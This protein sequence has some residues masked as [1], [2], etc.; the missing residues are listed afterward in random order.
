MHCYLINLPT[1]PSLVLLIRQ[2]CFA[3]RLPATARERLRRPQNLQRDL[4]A[5]QALGRFTSSGKLHS[6][7]GAPNRRAVILQLRI[8][9]L[10]RYW[11]SKLTNRGLT[12]R[13]T[14][15]ATAGSARLARS[16]FATVARQPYAAR[17]RGPVTSNVRHH[18]RTAAPRP[19]YSS[20][21]LS[22]RAPKSKEKQ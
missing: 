16:G 10:A 13:S 5:T 20:S 7:R 3:Q 4:R 15:P 18:K 11:F 9:Y 19:P 17:L 6:H 22:A 8:K 12:L 14:G 21:N 2:R 1:S